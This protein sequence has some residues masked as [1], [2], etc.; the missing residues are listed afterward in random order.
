VKREAIYSP[1]TLQLAVQGSRSKVNAV[2]HVNIKYQNIDCQRYFD[3]ANISN[4]DMILGTLWIYQHS[5]CVG[6]NPA[7]VII[8]SDKPLPL[9]SGPETKFVVQSID[10]TSDE[11]EAARIELQKY[12]DPLCK[13][14]SETE[15][16][17]LRAINHT[18][19]LIDMN[20]VYPWRPSRC[21]EV[22]RSQWNKK[23]ADYVGTG[24]W[25]ITSAGNTVPM[26]LIPNP[27]KGDAPPGALVFL[28]GKRAPSVPRLAR[29]MNHKNLV[30]LVICVC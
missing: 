15:L 11:I 29:F 20:K 6:L 2:A 8:G 23:C 1:V 26:L 4:Y 27:K 21:P 7:R 9:K 5:V 10:V 30:L 12:D 22:L 3:I 14:V 16:P 17:P 18:I 19:P 13:D 24:R 25:E 28:R